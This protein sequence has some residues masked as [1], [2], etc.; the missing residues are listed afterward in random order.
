MAMVLQCR[1]AVTSDKL[2]HPAVT[3]GELLMQHSH[4]VQMQQHDVADDYLTVLDDS[5]VH[6]PDERALSLTRL[7]CSR[8]LQTVHGLAYRQVAGHGISGLYQ[9]EF[10]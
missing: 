8:A 2:T 10:E 4:I 3:S 9:H 5:G 6:R 7:W 1:F